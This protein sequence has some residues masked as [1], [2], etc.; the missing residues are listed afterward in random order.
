[1][2][3]RIIFLSTDGCCI[4]VLLLFA[5]SCFGF[6]NAFSL[7]FAERSEL[8]DLSQLF[9]LLCRVNLIV[10]PECIVHDIVHDALLLECRLRLLLFLAL[11]SCSATAWR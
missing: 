7:N 8:G 4:K 5:R 1:M 2:V 6:N 3:L 11:S 9:L 10:E